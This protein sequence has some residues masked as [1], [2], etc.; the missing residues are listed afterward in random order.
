MS[1]DN[2]ATRFIKRSADGWFNLFTNMGVRGK[3]KRVETTFG[4]APR[5]SKGD[6]TELFRGDGLASRIIKIPAGDM[7][8]EWFKVIGDTDGYV[9]TKLSKIKANFIFE[10]ALLWDRLF[11]GAVILMYIDDGGDLEKAVN[12]NNIND[13]LG[14][15]VYDRWDVSWSSVDLYTDTSKVNY[16][17][18]QFYTVNN[19]STGSTFKVHESRIL[20]FTGETVPAITRVENQ[21]WG[22]N[23]LQV[24]YDRLRGLNDG[25]AGSEAVI[26]EFVTST[27]TIDNLGALLASPDGNKM[28]HDRLQI[29]DMSKHILNTYLLGKNE[30]FEKAS[31]TG[32]SGMAELVNQLIDALVA[33]SGIPR[34]RLFG[35]QTKGL[36]SEAA[37]NI[38]LYYDDIAALQE[39]KLRGP[40]EIITKY[41]MLCKNYA[42]KGKEVDNWS[43]SFNPLWQPTEDESAKTRKTVAETDKI[44]YDMN[45]PP[46]VIF[47]SRFGGDSYSS[48]T[49]LSQEL[50]D[51]YTDIIESKNFGTDD[52]DDTK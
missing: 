8:R 14:L 52:T 13:I 16:G 29:L 48:D 43:I 18:V 32:V 40:F 12:V 49:S 45:L 2:F 5:F 30:K 11:G 35:E 7:L 37:G 28:I 41:I 33:V 39:K 27:M 44:Y 31:A 15:Q 22:D 1:V 51:V 21:G 47:M 26:S 50:I 34:V 17:E 3:D 42:F 36:G 9:I 20:K 6:L 46:E 19:I 10:E 38:R 4:Q 25:Y 24:V 23:I